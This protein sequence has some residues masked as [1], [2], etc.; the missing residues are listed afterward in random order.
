MLLI[1]LTILI[2]DLLYHQYLIQKYCF[3]KFQF[4]DLTLIIKDP[5]NQFILLNYFSL[6]TLN[7]AVYALISNLVKILV[8]KFNS[9]MIKILPFPLFEIFSYV[10]SNP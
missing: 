2:I 7:I 1:L 4:I 9:S 3:L 6:F 10:K 8:Y 5:N